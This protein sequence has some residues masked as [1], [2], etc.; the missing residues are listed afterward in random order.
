MSSIVQYFDKIDNLFHISPSATKLYW[1]LVAQADAQG[2]I[3]ESYRSL[4]FR[5]GMSVNTIREASAE[6]TLAELVK[7]NVIGIKT[8]FAICYFQPTVSNFDTK[9]QQSVSNFDTKQQ[10]SVSNFDTKQQQSVSN[11]DTPATTQKPTVSN[12]DTVETRNTQ[13]VSNFDT[14][15]QQSVSNF[16]TPATTQK[17]T[18]S[19]FDT[20]ETRNTQTVSN[21]DTKQQKSVSNF[22]TLATTQKP[23]VSNF[24]TVETRNTQS[25]SNFD[26]K[27]QQSVSNFDTLATTQKPT[28]SNFDTVETRNTQSVSN[29]DTQ[30]AVNNNNINIK[31]IIINPITENENLDFLYKVDFQT[32]VAIQLKNPNYASGLIHEFQNK[33]SQKD[34]ENPFK[35]EQHFWNWLSKVRENYAYQTKCHNT[36]QTIA[37]NQ[38]K[39]KWLQVAEM[40]KN[41]GLDNSLIRSVRILSQENNKLIAE[42]ASPKVVEQLE[43]EPLFTHYSQ[44][45]KSCFGENILLEYTL[46]QQKKN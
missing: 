22:D 11:F 29:F 28:I 12:F 36:Y 42:V 32:K 16:D 9:Q 43:A 1:K 35:A 8:S 2:N 17:P 27:Q 15:Q 45:F 4:A 23:T 33:N 40:V 3:Q 5:T 19:N 21:F 31:D 26:T 46:R 41:R 24:D 38:A 6:L 39:K 13:T 10:Q 18:V 14:K 37:T 25:V 34:Y 30:F 44:A 7:M 20:V